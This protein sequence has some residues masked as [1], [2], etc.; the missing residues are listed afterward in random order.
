MMAQTLGIAGAVWVKFMINEDGRVSNV[1]V[2]EGIGGGCDE[3]AVHA[4]RQM[5]KWNPA[6]RNNVPVKSYYTL[7]IAFAYK[8]VGAIV[9]GNAPII[10]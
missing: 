10:P 9:K 1:S 3:V 4:V 6:I 8:K 2:V 7:G 5:P